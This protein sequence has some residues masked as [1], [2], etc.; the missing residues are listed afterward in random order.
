MTSG[1]NSFHHFPE[2]Q[3]TIDSAFLCKPTWETLP[4]PLSWYHLGEQCCPLIDVAWI[5]AVASLH[6]YNLD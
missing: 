1:G 6:C 4:L 5:S 3:L 2:N